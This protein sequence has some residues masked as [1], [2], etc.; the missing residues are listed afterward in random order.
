MPHF[1]SK[2]DFT[3]A[4]VNLCSPHKSIFSIS[5][6]LVYQSSEEGNDGSKIMFS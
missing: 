6:F 1:S 5:D 3:Q 2:Q 4:V